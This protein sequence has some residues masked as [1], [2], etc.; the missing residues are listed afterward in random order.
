[1]A[2]SGLN[3]LQEV[4]NIPF[5]VQQASEKKISLDSIRPRGEYLLEWKNGK[6]PGMELCF[7]DR[8]RKVSAKQIL[9]KGKIPCIGDKQLSE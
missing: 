7:F 1:M 8:N 4:N 3:G 2:L 9:Q 5:A 6:N